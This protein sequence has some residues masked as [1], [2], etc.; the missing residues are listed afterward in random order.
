MATK[1]I[2]VLVNSNTVRLLEREYNA[3]T[4]IAAR[5]V[6]AYPYLRRA[7][8]LEMHNVFTGNELLTLLD[9]F[10]KKY[11]ADALTDAQLVV[12]LNQHLWFVQL[13]FLL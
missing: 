1:R 10:D 2:S 8:I 7:T 13:D 6:D 3:V 9:V 12:F 4:R 5:L 11:P